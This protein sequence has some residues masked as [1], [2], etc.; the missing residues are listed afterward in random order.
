MTGQGRGETLRTQIRYSTMWS[1][2]ETGCTVSSQEAPR[3]EVSQRDA[4]AT[5][6]ARQQVDEAM[7]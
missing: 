1:K 7:V 6:A 2:D 3:K 4:M 5:L